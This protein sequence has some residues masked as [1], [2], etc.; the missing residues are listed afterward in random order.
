MVFFNTWPRSILPDAV[1][2]TSKNLES[3][4]TIVERCHLYI[5]TMVFHT[6][7]RSSASNQTLLYTDITSHHKHSHIIH[8]KSS[9]MT[10]SLYVADS[11]KISSLSMSNA[12]N[13]V[14]PCQTIVS[15]NKV[16][17]PSVNK[18]EVEDD[19]K[20]HADEE[21]GRSGMTRF[22]HKC[23]EREGVVELLECLERE[24]I[25]AEDVGKE[26]TDYNRRAQIFD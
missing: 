7:H 23:E 10:W 13:P 24:A 12:Y 25:M 20:P 8:P 14:I 17:Q 26:P 1:R 22:R 2:R 19:M 15:P 9:D 5:L 3:S 11:L 21:K 16:T 18:R 4:V 6:G